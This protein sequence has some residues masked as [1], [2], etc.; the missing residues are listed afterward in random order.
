MENTAETNRGVATFYAQT[1]Q[2]WR[3]WLAQN[4]QSAVAVC[5]ILYH[6]KSK[7]PSVSYVESVEEALCFGWIDSLT[8]KRNAESFYQRFSPRKPKS[9]W[10]Q[11]NR[12]RVARLA[13]EGLMTEHGQKTIDI[14]KAN[15]RWMPE[16]KPKNNQ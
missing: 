1:R 14:A 11:A 16:A 5:L 15:G 10:S 9:N 4:N 13:N 2:E 6:K 3:N 12:E 8:N 7:T